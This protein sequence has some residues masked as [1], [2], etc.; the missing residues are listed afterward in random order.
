MNKAEKDEG[1]D[2][3]FL[4]VWVAPLNLSLFH[5][6][7]NYRET[8]QIIQNQVLRGYTRT[9]ISTREIAYVR[10]ICHFYCHF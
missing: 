5:F 6:P 9:W 7:Q 10:I 3:I 4:Y 8:D 2:S 1:A